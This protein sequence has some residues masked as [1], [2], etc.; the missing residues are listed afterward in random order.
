MPAGGGY[1]RIKKL[2]REELKLF[3][4]E[5][6]K[7]LTEDEA[8]AVIENPYVT[9]GLLQAVAHSQRLTGYYSVRL[10][11]VAH[12]QTPQ[13]HSVKL[14]HYLYWFDLVRLSVDMTIPAPVRRAIDTQLLLRADKLTLG[15]RIAT[16]RR[17]SS[18]LIKIFLKDTDI[19]V[20][21]VALLNQ[22]VREDDVL[23]AIAAPSVT[24][25]QLRL[26]A[27]NQKWSYRYAV[28]KA[29]VLHPLTPRS[30]SAT[31]LRYLTRRDRR[32]IHQN[33]TTSTYLRRCIDSLDAKDF[34]A[35]AERIE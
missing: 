1:H 30:A 25:E 23:A 33:P 24:A 32:L 3:V 29:L 7:S 34:S 26:I 9:N 20:F 19:R 8:L 17:C 31:Q 10:R 4:T 11:L 2:P 27:D 16:A 35:H 28:R 21:S 12:R 18:E 15:E 6:I 14:I 13:A 5:N 22:R